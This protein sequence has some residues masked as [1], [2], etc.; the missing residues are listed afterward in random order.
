MDEFDRCAPVRVALRV[1]A[2]TV[3]IVAEDRRT[4]EVQVTP[5]D[6]SAAAREAA[7]Q[8]RVELDGDT[9]LIQQPGSSWRR[10]PK[11]RITA[12]VP[13]GST[14]TGKSAS[15]DVRDVSGRLL[16]GDVTG[17][18]TLGTA[19]RQHPPARRR[20]LGPGRLGERQHR[21]R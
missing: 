10:A 17:D 1:Q 16:I 9:L 11:L 7:A 20:R 19:K 12:R 6:D 21:D 3:E 15:V 5:L 8:T 4:T 13:A 2:G 18:V 14:L